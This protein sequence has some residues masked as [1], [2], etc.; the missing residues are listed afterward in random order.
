MNHEN[1]HKL[2]DMLMNLPLETPFDMGYWQRCGTPS[3]AA[4][5]FAAL[6]PESGFKLQRSHR[7]YEGNLERLMEVF[8]ISEYDCEYLFVFYEGAKTP[9]KMAAR[10]RK[11]VEQRP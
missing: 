5:W 1:F 2:Y 3:C 8:D 7:I 6:H 10:V 4:G 9:R 11:Y